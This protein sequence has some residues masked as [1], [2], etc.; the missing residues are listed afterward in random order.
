MKDKFISL[1][2]VQSSS[3]L[4]PIAPI[5]LPFL[6]YICTICTVVT[7]HVTQVDMCW[8]QL[9]VVDIKN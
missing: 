5:N 6:V 2:N 3:I 8:G 4:L 9:E 7:L 1:R